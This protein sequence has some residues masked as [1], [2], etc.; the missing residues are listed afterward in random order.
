VKPVVS[1]KELA[2]AIGVSESSMKRWADSGK[3]TVSRTAGGHRR[4]PIHEAIRF[5]RDTRSPLL[6]PD[7]LG[8]ES[9]PTSTDDISPTD[10]AARFSRILIDGDTAAARSMMMALYLD[11]VSVADIIDDVVQPSMQDIGTRWEHDSTGVYEEHRATDICIQAMTELRLALPQVPNAPIALGGAPSGDPYIL[12]SMAAAM[13]LAAEGFS[14]VNLGPNSPL[15][16]FSDAVNANQP[17]LVW[18]TVSH[19]T[20]PAA[21]NRSVKEFLDWASQKSLQIIVGGFQIQGLDPTVLQGVRVGR[22]M[23]ELAAFAHGLHTGGR[24]SNNGNGNG[25]NGGSQSD[26]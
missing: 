25:S 16:S 9:A 6:R 5:I 15:D 26:Q 17:K 14:A 20:N 10:A 21:I 24:V 3:I 2:L 23:R 7:I 11:G 22:S 4:I 19:I 1:P 13:V 18:L 8:L 12:P